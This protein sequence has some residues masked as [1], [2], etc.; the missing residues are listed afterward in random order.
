[1][2]DRSP[3]RSLDRWLFLGGP[4]LA[5]VAGYVNVVLLIRFAIPVSHVTGAVAHIG[6]DGLRGETQAA[7]L[8]ITVVLGF[9]LGALTSGYAMGEPIFRHRRRYGLLFIVQGLLFL[10]AGAAM[11]AGHWLAAPL[12]ALGCG[13]QNALASSYR[14][15]NL[16]TTHMTGIVT[17][18]GILLGLRLRG[19]QVQDWRLL[20]LC[21]IFLGYL[22]GTVVGVLLASQLQAYALLPAGGTCLCGGAIY[23][24][25]RPAVRD[26]E[27]QR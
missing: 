17:D 1:M 8:A 26:P 2:P 7:L 10:L 24:L 4:L 20:L 14:S 23:L 19:R 15:L 18:I 9:F 13:M 11:V 6:L 12:A 27:V 3:H 16:R 22:G 25:A 5:L 21:A